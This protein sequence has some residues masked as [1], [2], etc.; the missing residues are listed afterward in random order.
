MKKWK[1]NVIELMFNNDIKIPEGTPRYKYGLFSIEF[2]LDKNHNYEL[3]REGMLVNTIRRE[4]NEKF[5]KI[6]IMGGDL[7]IN[8]TDKEA[9]FFIIKKVKE[10]ED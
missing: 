6:C 10:N 7:L 2:P 8:V 5:D 1:D 3:Y 9:T 4:W